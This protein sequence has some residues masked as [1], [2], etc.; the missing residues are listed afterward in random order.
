MLEL[1]LQWWQW[2]RLRSWNVV[3]LWLPLPAASHDVFF[4]IIIVAFLIKI[5]RIDIQSVIIVLTAMLLVL[6]IATLA[7]STQH[8]SLG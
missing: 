3:V 2:L 6:A 5:I 7:K 8:I 1:W 4:T